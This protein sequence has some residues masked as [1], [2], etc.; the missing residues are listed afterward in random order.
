MPHA[1]RQAQ[2][3]MLAKNADAFKATYGSDTGSQYAQIAT[4]YCPTAKSSSVKE[5]LTALGYTK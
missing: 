3:D 5:L 4:I 1:D 2:V